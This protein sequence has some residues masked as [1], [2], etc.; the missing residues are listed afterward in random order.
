MKLSAWALVPE[1][2]WVSSPYTTA[3]FDSLRGANTASQFINQMCF[4]CF[5]MFKDVWIDLE[6]KVLLFLLL[7]K[8]S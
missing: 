5:K 2:N 3:L 1:L 8:P 6:E 7:L 4:L